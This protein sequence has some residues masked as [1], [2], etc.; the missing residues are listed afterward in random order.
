MQPPLPV[1]VAGGVLAL[2][3]LVAVLRARSSESTD[4]GSRLGGSYEQRD[5]RVGRG[6]DFDGDGVGDRTRSG[7]ADMS[8]QSWDDEE[9]TE[10]VMDAAEGSKESGWNQL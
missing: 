9:G 7:E 1:V 4:L 5:H 6:E 8:D 2:G 3:F 10:D